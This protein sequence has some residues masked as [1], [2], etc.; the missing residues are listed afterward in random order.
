MMARI[1]GVSLLSLLVVVA[2]L[3][4]SVSEVNAQQLSFTY[5]RKSCPNV[6][7]IVLAEVKKAFK[8]NPTIAP[9]ILR[10]MFHDCFVRVS[11]ISL[12]LFF[13]TRNLRLSSQRI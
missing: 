1:Q 8:K 12:L 9:G 2:V 3:A 7:S 4:L 13:S 5:Y 10:M 6:E 11:I